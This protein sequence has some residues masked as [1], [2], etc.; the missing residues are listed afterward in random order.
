MPTDQSGRY[1]KPADRC[2]GHHSTAAARRTH[3]LK[4]DNM[5]LV[6]YSTCLESMVT[7]TV[8][9][10]RRTPNMLAKI[11]FICSLFFSVY[12]TTKAK[13]I[14]PYLLDVRLKRECL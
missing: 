7:Y 9:A 12:L 13:I 4:S 10:L 11:Y 6:S 3:I 1:I 14:A 5:K 8:D 2:R